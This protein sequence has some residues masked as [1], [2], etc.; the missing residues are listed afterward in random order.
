MAQVDLEKY[1]LLIL[2]TAVYRFQQ[3]LT[4]P[5]E[6]LLCPRQHADSCMFVH[7]RRVW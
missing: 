2:Y 7:W 6:L 5:K 1:V 4:K 3:I